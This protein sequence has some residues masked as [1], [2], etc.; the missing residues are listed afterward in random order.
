[1]IPFPYLQGTTLAGLDSGES[2]T[3]VADNSDLLGPAA[4]G[5]SPIGGTGIV[6]VNNFRVQDSYPTIS[7]VT[8]HWSLVL[9][10][11]MDGH[12]A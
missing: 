2:I 1:M 4:S 5:I 7:L 8:V 3:Y 11:E 12:T 9:E 10:Q 6:C